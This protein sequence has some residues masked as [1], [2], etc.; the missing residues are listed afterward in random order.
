MPKPSSQLGKEQVVCPHLPAVDNIY[1]NHSSTTS[2]ESFHDRSIIIVGGDACQKTVNQLA[3]Y[4]ADVPPVVSITTK[5][6]VPSN[7]VVSL[8]R[9][10]ITGT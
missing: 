7:T 8:I 6:P 3:R 9:G 1:H 4:Y 10:T 2:K 5:A